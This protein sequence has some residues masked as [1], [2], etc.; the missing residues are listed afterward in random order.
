MLVG[1]VANLLAVLPLATQGMRDTQAL[2]V[3]RVAE[4]AVRTAED[5]RL[6]GV[7]GVDEILSISSTPDGE[8]VAP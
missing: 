1:A 5:A 4:A 6:S 7:L 8:V 3:E 2:R